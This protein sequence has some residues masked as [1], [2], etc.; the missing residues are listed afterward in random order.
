M[1]DPEASSRLPI[2]LGRTMSVGSLLLVLVFLVKAYAVARYSLTTMTGLVVAT[3]VQVALGTVSFYAYLV[4]PALALA[5]GWLTVR[6]LTAP[7][8][9]QV[10]AAAWPILGGIT[11]VSALMSPVQYLGTG[12]ALLAVCLRLELRIRWFLRDGGA[13]G[14][15]PG[16]TWWWRPHDRWAPVPAWVG[17]PRWPSMPWRLRLSAWALLGAAV[18]GASGFPQFRGPGLILVAVGVAAEAP[19]SVWLQQVLNHPRVLGIRRGLRAGARPNT[20]SGPATASGGPVRPSPVRRAV[21]GQLRGR[22]LGYLGTVAMIWYFVGTVETPWVPAQLYVLT[23]PVDVSTQDKSVADRVLDVERVRALIGFPLTRDGE[24]LTVLDAGTRRIVHIPATAIRAEP[25]CHSDE[26]QLIGQRPLL[27]QLLGTRYGSHNINCETMRELLVPPR[28]LAFDP[29]GTVLAGTGWDGALGL[30]NP[31][32][33]RALGAPTPAPAEERVP[34]PPESGQ[35]PYPVAFA[36]VTT[37]LAAAGPDGT[38]SLR[39]TGTYR[40]QLTLPSHRD[41]AGHPAAVTALAFTPDGRALAACADDVVRIWDLTAF[42]ASPDAPGRSSP[43]T[44]ENLVPAPVVLRP[45]PGDAVNALAV[46]G[47]DPRTIL[48]AGGDDDRIRL[49]DLSDPAR[50]VQLGAP[51][52]VHQPAEAGAAPRNAVYAVAISPDGMILAAA[53]GRRD[54]ARGRFPTVYHADA[55]VRMWDI[56]PATHPRPLGRP[57]TGHTGAVNALAFNPEGRILA[58]G[59]SD[60]TVRLWDVSL[61]DEPGP[62]GEPLSGHTGAVDTIVFRPVGAGGAM[63]LATTGTDQTIRLWDLPAG[64][65]RTVLTPP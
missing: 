29:A 51:L 16:W 2:D 43:G 10:I 40:V 18:A 53:G 47:G 4:M 64:R 45:S 52:S 58:S 56:A 39:D 49:W 32:T 36:P 17:V 30:W 20:A 19:F 41:L 38:V 46:A 1:I 11:A 61:F 35:V 27:W 57:L 55:A 23:S 34:A 33:G 48:A 14:S 9:S 24:N 42:I 22:T 37:F 3:P 25:V 59:S 31:V 54:M 12:F 65:T 26:D 62:H 60:S 7:D 21:A 8:R 63:T 28:G 13:A 50:P 44:S 5:T 15:A 6:R